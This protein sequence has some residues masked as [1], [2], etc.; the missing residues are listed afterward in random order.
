MA[1]IWIITLTYCTL[2]QL[3]SMDD[4]WLFKENEGYG[5]RGVTNNCY[6]IKHIIHDEICHQGQMKIIRKRL[7]R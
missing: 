1:M 7:S 6:L 3:K 5:N 4:E 2:E